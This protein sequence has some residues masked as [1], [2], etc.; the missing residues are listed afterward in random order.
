MTEEFFLPGE[1]NCH[2]PY[3]LQMDPAVF[4]FSGRRF[5]LISLKLL[6]E[7]QL[8]YSLLKWSD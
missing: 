7:K 2:S 6:D 5:K 8:E 3:T 4:Y 1:E